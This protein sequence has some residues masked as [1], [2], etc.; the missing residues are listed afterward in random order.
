MARD[1]ADV[2]HTPKHVSVTVVEHVLSGEGQRGQT[3]QVVI[4][5]HLESH[6]GN[7]KQMYFMLKQINELNFLFIIIIIHHHISFSS[8]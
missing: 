6:C 8:L 4:R 5:F 3:S 1:P 7:S 2:R